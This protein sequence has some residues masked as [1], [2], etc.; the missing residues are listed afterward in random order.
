MYLKHWSRCKIT[1]DKSPGIYLPFLTLFFMEYLVCYL[2]IFRFQALF[3]TLGNIFDSRIWTVYWRHRKKIWELD[4]IKMND[5][6]VI[7][8]GL[9]CTKPHRTSL[10]SY[11][12]RGVYIQNPSTHKNYVTACHP[13]HPTIPG[14]YL[15]NYIN[16]EN[17]R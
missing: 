9:S 10:L 6:E 13:L 17:G 8:G 14:K 15:W 1:I 16:K 11:I 3:N 12:G 5:E 7:W 4:A 2:H